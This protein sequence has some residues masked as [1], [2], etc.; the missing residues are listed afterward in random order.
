MSVQQQTV[1]ITG[2]RTDWA[3]PQ[4]YCW[5]SADIEF[6]QRG[7]PRRNAKNGS[8]GDGPAS[9]RSRLLLWTFVMTPRCR[10]PYNAFC[11]RLAQLMC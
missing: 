8:L 9:A 7:D 3:N 5:R 10:P 11:K 2:V 4:Q 1:L 6:S